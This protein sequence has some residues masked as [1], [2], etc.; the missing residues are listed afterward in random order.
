MSASSDFGGPAKEPKAIKPDLAGERKAQ[1]KEKNIS[2]I[3]KVSDEQ[4]EPDESNRTALGKK[5]LLA[6]SS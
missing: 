2:I 6:L 5:S 1:A 3:R 4:V